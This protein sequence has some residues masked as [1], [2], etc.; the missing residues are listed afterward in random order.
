MTVRSAIES[1]VAQVVIDIGSTVVK[2]ALA[3]EDHSILSQK[4]YPRDFEAGIVKQVESLIDSLEVSGSAD[5]RVCSSANGGLRVGIL[6]LTKRFSGTALRHQV[7]LAGA[8][9]I[10]VHSFEEAGKDTGYADVLLVGGGVDCADATPLKQRINILDLDKYR[11]GTLIFTGNKHLA[12]RFRSRFPSALVIQN[13]LSESLASDNNTV[14]EVIRRAY[15]DDLVYKEGISELRGNLSAGIRPTPEVVSRGF[16]HAVLNSAASGVIAPCLLLDIGGA[17]TDVHYTVE[18]VKNG[19]G[20]KAVAG[21]S[22]ARYVF[23]DLGIVAS[24]DSLMLQMRGHPRLY[25]FLS[26]VLSDDVTEAYRLFRE[27]EYRPSPA[28]LAYGCLFLA[29]DRFAQGRGPGLPCGDLGQ[30]SQV[31]LTGGGAQTLSEDVAADVVSLVA[32]KS[33]RPVML[34]DRK[35]EMWVRG[36]T[37]AA[38][39]VAAAAV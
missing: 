9:P 17:T 28:V 24:R 29:L 30:L 22:V 19:S 27:G 26:T 25:E 31:I 6:C 1:R 13:P 15:L 33:S 21:S 10:F 7:L 3:G 37:F 34:I 5:I 20:T 14:F 35:Y 23:T 4:F 38:P 11:Y 32:P 39:A 12:G 18:I 8:N 16:L 36:L 2:V